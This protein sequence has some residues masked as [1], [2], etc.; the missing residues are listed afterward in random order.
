MVA[1]DVSGDRGLDCDRVLAGTRCGSKGPQL[2]RLLP[3]QPRLLPGGADRC[4]H[5]F[6]QVGL[7]N[8]IERGFM[9]DI[10]TELLNQD[11]DLDSLGPVDYIVVEFPAGASNFTGEMAEELVAL[12]DAGTIR[13]IDI[14][15]LTKDADGTVEAM[16]LSEIEELGPLRAIEA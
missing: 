13:V 16:E 3:L 14:L 6:G 5:G 7:R 9:T 11:R 10:T 12:V 1:L 15:I 4:L 2:H 8:R